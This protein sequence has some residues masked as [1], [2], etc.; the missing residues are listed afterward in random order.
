M[1]SGRR[2]FTGA[3]K[4]ATLA[5]V[6]RDEPPPIAKIPHELEK[7]IARCLRKDPAR[8]AQ[9][10]ADLRLAPEELN[11]ESSP[12]LRLAVSRLPGFR[13]ADAG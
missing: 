8:R 12:A 1:L 6:V 2:A 7:L 3:S 9:H 10:M 13:P 5:A 4:Q 11:D